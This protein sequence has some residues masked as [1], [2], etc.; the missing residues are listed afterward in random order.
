DLPA[1]R[2]PDRLDRAAPFPD[3]DPLLAGALDVDHGSNIHRLLTLSELVDL[4]GHTVRQ[5]FVQQLE[6]RLAHELGGEEAHRLRRYRVGIVVK[7]ALGKLRAQH[8][9]ESVEAFAGERGDGDA[10]GWWRWG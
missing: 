10:G 6:R 9:E 7:R 2:L 1:G 8:V 5:F 4:D 3:H